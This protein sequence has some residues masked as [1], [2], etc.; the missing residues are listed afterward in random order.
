MSALQ[1]LEHKGAAAPD[2][3][4]P[5]FLKSLDPL[6]VQ[7]LL[8]IFNASFHLA[9]CPWIWRVAIII[10]LLIVGKSP[11]DVTSFWPISLTSCIVKLLECI[12]SLRSFFT[13][14]WA[15]VQLHNVSS[16]LFEVIRTISSEFICFNEKTRKKSINKTIQKQKSLNKTKISKQKT[17]KTTIFC[18][19]KLSRGRKLFILRF[20]AFFT[21]KVFS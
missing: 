18:S 13:D 16:I 19:K 21:L 7:E 6:A 15:R 10:P 5:K 11:S 1:K 17:T 3:I 9:D 4:A 12:R 14:R 2:N 20:G 8:F